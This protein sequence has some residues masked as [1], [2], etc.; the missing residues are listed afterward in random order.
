MGLASSWILCRVL[1][2]LSHS[3]NSRP[4]PPLFF[5]PLKCLFLL[6]FFFFL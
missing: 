5:L 1:N 4:P 6:I 3:G 2:P